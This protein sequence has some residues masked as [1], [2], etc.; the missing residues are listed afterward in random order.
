MGQDLSAAVQ[1]IGT[2]VTAII[3]LYLL[4][5]GQR[6]RRLLR[7][8]Q[9]RV[10][11]SLVS[12]S[13]IIEQRQGAAGSDYL[14]DHCRAIVL[15]QSESVIHLEGL[16]LVEGGEQWDALVREGRYSL[17]AQGM[18]VLDHLLLP[19]ALR[20]IPLPSG[21]FPE[22]GVG[23]QFVIVDFTDAA[24]RRWRRRSDTYDLERRHRR[25]NTWQL[26][27]QRASSRLSLLHKVAFQW[28]S[29]WAVR[30]AKKR[31]N[32]L[33]LSLRWCRL[34][35]GYWPGGEE[36]AW[37][38]PN[39]APILWDFEGLWQVAYLKLVDEVGNAE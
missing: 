13:T 36:D 25:A 23:G 5:Q 3:A 28:P 26:R 30:A 18:A 12:L 37:L 7:A 14:L 20:E 1:A 21:W 9:E 27:F 32:K 10:Q 2:A 35:W 31:P 19:R 4:W 22:P 15:N 34:L 6:D 33:P 8:E 17:R 38:R 24:G 11:A 39:G 29:T 16:T